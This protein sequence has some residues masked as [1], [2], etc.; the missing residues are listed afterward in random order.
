MFDLLKYIRIF[1]D[2]M[3]AGLEV[4][5][6]DNDIRE[7]NMVIIKKE[8]SAVLIEKATN[9][10]V[11]VDEILNYLPSKLPV[12]L[13]INGKGILTK[14]VDVK[15]NNTQPLIEKVLPNVSTDEFIFNSTSSQSDTVFVTI[16]RKKIVDQILEEISHLNLHIVELLIGHTCIEG[17]LPL[18]NVLP[19]EINLPSARILLKQNKITQILIG[20]SEFNNCGYQLG[21][22]S[23]AGYSLPAFAAAINFLVIN[24]GIPSS[25]YD[26]ILNSYKEYAYFKKFKIVGWTALIIIFLTLLVNYL[27]FERYN[28]RY[29]QLSSEVTGY[30]E[31]ISQH[32]S[33]NDELARK[34][35]LLNETG[36]LNSSLISFY[37]DR[38]ANDLPNGITFTEM[39]LNPSIEK[40]SFKKD[41]SFET[42]IIQVTGTTNK[43]T[44]L[45]EWIKTIKQYNWIEGVTN[46][47]Y[48]INTRVGRSAN[49]FSIELI[50][51]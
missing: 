18:L 37:S 43:S 29:N 13:V 46:I 27:I 14:E 50:L 47:N 15:E 3:A 35:L 20:Q 9:T 40:H 38:L 2:K 7:Y 26:K 32:N 31:L 36:I 21:D 34:E 4:I 44:T 23:L 12:S 42:G 22:E 24:S 5:I 6:K 39:H 41:Y 51:K 25:K 1:D 10:F 45:N 33:L 17:I 19:N 30:S 49:T 28:S 8:K 11:S 48:N 16:I